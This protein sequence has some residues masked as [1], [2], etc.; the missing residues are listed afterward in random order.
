MN[1]LKP[2]LKMESILLEWIL[3]VKGIFVLYRVRISGRPEI[4]LFFF[5]AFILMSLYTF[6]GCLLIA[7]G[8]ILSIFFL[9]I[10]PN[11]QYVLLMVSR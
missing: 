11:A 6:F 7:Y 10:A 3:T 8:P 5:H 4:Q 1:R 9:Y 2:L